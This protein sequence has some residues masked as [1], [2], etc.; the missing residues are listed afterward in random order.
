MTFD[1]APGSG[2]STCTGSPA[3]VSGV[4][5]AANKT[6]LQWSAE[7][8]GNAYDVARGMLDGLDVGSPATC[9]ATGMVGLQ[10]DDFGIPSA[11]QGYYYL[12]RATNDCGV[13]AWGSGSA[14][15][16]RSACP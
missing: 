5:I 15:Q 13:G 3:E 8:S 11:G 10:Y 7:P 12:L 2:G 6:T 4:V 16:S 9:L 14:G 1:V